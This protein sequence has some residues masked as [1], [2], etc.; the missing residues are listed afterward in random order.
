[1]RSAILLALVS[2]VIEG[3][4]EGRSYKRIRL[5]PDNDPCRQVHVSSVCDRETGLCTNLYYLNNREDIVFYYGDDSERFVDQIENTRVE[6]NQPESTQRLEL[7]EPDFAHVRSVYDRLIGYTCKSALQ[8]AH[9]FPFPF[10]FDMPSINRDLDAILETSASRGVELQLAIRAVI[11]SSEFQSVAELVESFSRSV[12]ALS[13]WRYRPLYRSL[14][15]LAY[16]ASLDKIFQVSGGYSIA[17]IIAAPANRSLTARLARLYPASH[18]SGVGTTPTKGLAFYSAPLST[19]LPPSF[20][21]AEILESG[22][23]ELWTWLEA[24]VEYRHAL[25]QELMPKFENFVRL[26][27]LFAAAEDA[28]EDRVRPHFNT[29]VC[30]HFA[31]F[32]HFFGQAYSN[33]DSIALLTT[34]S[35]LCKDEVSYEDKLYVSGIIGDRLANQGRKVDNVLALVESTPEGIVEESRLFLKRDDV[36]LSGELTIASAAGV[37]RE[38]WIAMMANHL[39]SFDAERIENMFEYIPN[40]DNLLLIAF[41]SGASMELIRATGRIIGLVLKYDVP[42]SINFAPSFIMGLGLIAKL[43]SIQDYSLMA[44]DEVFQPLMEHFLPVAQRAEYRYDDINSRLFFAFAE[45]FA[46][47]RDGIADVIGPAA[48]H[49]LPVK[50]LTDRLCHDPHDRFQIDFSRYIDQDPCYSLNSNSQC[51]DGYCTDL[52]WIREDQGVFFYS[53]IAYTP[54]PRVSCKAAASVHFVSHHF[55]SIHFNRVLENLRN[56]LVDTFVPIVQAFPVWSNLEALSALESIVESFRDDSF[57]PLENEAAFKVIGAMEEMLLLERYLDNVCLSYSTLPP[58]YKDHLSLQLS[59]ILS[60][61]ELFRR[62][63][64]DGM[65]SVLHAASRQPDVAMRGMQTTGAP[66][67]EPAIDDMS[68]SGGYGKSHQEMEKVFE[69]LALAA[70]PVLQPLSDSGTFPIPPRG[71][72]EHSVD[73]LREFVEAPAVATIAA[74]SQFDTLICQNLKGLS[75]LL[76]K[77]A[78]PE[79]LSLNARLLELCKDHLDFTYKVVVSSLM[80]RDVKPCIRLRMPQFPRETMIRQSVAF[81]LNPSSPVGTRS[82]LVSFGENQIGWIGV[83]KVWINHVADHLL[84]VNDQLNI[85]EFT[86]ESRSLIT[87]AKG[88]SRDYLRAAGRLIGLALK[89]DVPISTSF[90]PSL[91]RGLRIVSSPPTD[92]ELEAMTRFE[93]ETFFKV[94]TSSASPEFIADNPGIVEFDGLGALQGDVAPEQAQLFKTLRVAKKMFFDR[95]FEL[96]ALRDGIFQV[97]GSAVFDIITDQELADRLCSPIPLTPQII[98]DGISFPGFYQQIDRFIRNLA[99]EDPE[100]EAVERQ[101][102]ILARKNA[103]DFLWQVISEFNQEDLLLFNSFVTG[104]DRRPVSDGPWIKVHIYAELGDTHLPRSH[105]CHNE[106]QLPLYS[107]VEV[108]REQ[109]LKAIR[110]GQTLEGHVDYRRRLG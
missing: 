110:Y 79:S 13:V 87:V 91:I 26:V 45:E 4:D 12:L 58:Q 82:L 72:V 47:L 14:S 57:R 86:D 24:D 64:T 94:I 38:A 23:L 22:H 65:K 103:R 8:M 50:E 54:F 67:V 61:Y 15:D 85:F 75:V 90:A 30:S 104:M 48:L 62:P 5:E 102:Q 106:L 27:R 89:F 97:T 51:V 105:T 99:I 78:F 93:D 76:H 71:S 80:R 6:C 74:G 63:L 53:K 88:A 32:V 11:Y 10:S 56:G 77:W 7:V 42:V 33:R 40:T 107:N 36:V 9:K 46:I 28:L 39:L 1:M 21:V 84:T 96:A 95:S 41:G 43:P 29:H 108:A 68:Q 81:L 59:R 52:Y 69:E 55:H 34:L 35:E 98:L 92:V 3:S 2:N 18:L 109:I 83:R 25:S 73:R 20:N 60:I 16:F 17:A 19:R 44:V 49:L 31:Q 66:E 37:S 100:V 101:H 70:R